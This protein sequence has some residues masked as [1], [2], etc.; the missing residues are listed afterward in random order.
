ML[1]AV[2]KMLVDRKDLCE[3]LGVSLSHVI[4]LEQFGRLAKARIEVG[5]RVV[6]YDMRQVRRLIDTRKLY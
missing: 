1:K 2:N 5:P 3:I 6:R 4:R